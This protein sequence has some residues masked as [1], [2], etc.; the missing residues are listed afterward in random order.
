MKKFVLYLFTLITFLSLT[1]LLSDYSGQVTILWKSWRIETS[2]SVSIAIIILFIIVNLILVRFT[3]Y[4]K[5]RNKELNFIKKERQIEKGLN[6]ISSGFSEI[7]KGDL[8]TARKEL[9]KAEAVLGSHEVVR[10][11][12]KQIKKYTE[13][14]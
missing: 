14:E 12:E 4:I 3:N 10:L 8:N 5:N 2:L 7:Y 1:I 13:N 6:A 11:M 9:E